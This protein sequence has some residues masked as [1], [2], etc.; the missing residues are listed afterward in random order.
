MDK[1]RTVYYILLTTWVVAVIALFW[2]G[3]VESRNAPRVIIRWQEPEV[4]TIGNITVTEVTIVNN[5]LYIILSNNK[6][7]EEAIP[8]EVKL[9]DTAKE[10][11]ILS[12]VVFFTGFLLLQLIPLPKTDC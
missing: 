1:T 12:A 2:K 4:R 5:K 3:A 6:V 11:L 7:I 9:D 10:Y 8:V